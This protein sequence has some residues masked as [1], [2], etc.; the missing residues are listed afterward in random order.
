M[1]NI[2]R[3][4]ML[5]QLGRRELSRL[6]PTGDRSPPADSGEQQAQDASRNEMVP[7]GGLA[8]RWRAPCTKRMSSAVPLSEQAEVAT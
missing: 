8:F 5:Q 6:T 7:A 4:T 1:R 2:L 3:H